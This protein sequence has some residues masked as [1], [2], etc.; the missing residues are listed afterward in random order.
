VLEAFEDDLNTA[1]AVRLLRQWERE[2]TASSETKV[3]TLLACD[4]LLGL[5]LGA[6]P[7]TDAFDA[8][9]PQEIQDLA[10]ARDLA[11]ANKDWSQSDSLRDELLSRGWNVTDA[12]EGQRLSPRQR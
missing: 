1:A 9:I 3:A 11:R 6:P 8:D 7:T 4:E 10:T 2:S 5:N 12:V